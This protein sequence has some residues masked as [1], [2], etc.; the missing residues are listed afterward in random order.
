MTI[1]VIEKTPF[2]KENLY[3]LIF[4]KIDYIQG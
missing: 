1:K 3:P 4:K 2:G